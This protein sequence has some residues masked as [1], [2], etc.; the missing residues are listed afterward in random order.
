MKNW[1]MIGRK[2]YE[3]IAFSPQQWFKL[4]DHL[5]QSAKLLKPRAA[6]ARDSMSEHFKDRSIRPKLD[7][8][9]ATYLMLTSYAIENLLKGELVNRNAISLRAD[10]GFLKK[11]KLPAKLCTHNLLELA[12]ELKLEFDVEA[13]A[14]LLRLQR[15]AIWN[16]RYPVPL[17]YK[18]TDNKQNHRGRDFFIGYLVLSDLDYLPVLVADIRRQL[19]IRVLPSEFRKKRLKSSYNRKRLKGHR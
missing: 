8:Y 17:D 13:Q 3:A 5:L 7:H 18:A 16:G 14:T 10:P 15:S 1:D 9:T 2:N 12:D 4:A 11:G 6:R 19:D